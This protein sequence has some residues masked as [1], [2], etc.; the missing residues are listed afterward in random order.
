MQTNKFGEIIYSQDD[1]C[2]I[3]MQ[4]RDVTDIKNLTVDFDVDI[5]H[6][7]AQLEDTGS[8]QTWDQ[9]SNSDISVQEFDRM[10]QGHWFMP[11]EYRQLDIAEHVLTLCNTQEEL[12]RV[13]QELLLFQERDM[14][15]LLKY[16]VYLVD[17]MKQNQVIWGVGRGSAVASYVLYLLGVHRINSM[18]YDLDPHEFLR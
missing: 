14:F 11:E 12:Q 8:I 2:N 9:A 16:L 18:F 17:V 15:D 10:R 3:V 7:I 5:E 6:L 1:I 4:G 13:G